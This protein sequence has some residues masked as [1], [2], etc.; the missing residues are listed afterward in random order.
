MPRIF[1]TGTSACITLTA[2]VQRPDL[3]V[4]ITGSGSV[5]AATGPAIA[6][7]APHAWTI[8]NRGT[9]VSDDTMSAAIALDAGGMVVNA[10][11][12]AITGGTGIRIDGVAGTVVNWGRID[13]MQDSGIV[14]SAGGS[15]A[16]RGT[17]TGLAYGVRLVAGG[18]L[19]N[20]GTV[21]A[22]TPGYYH[23]YALGG[24]A[25]QIEG[26][27]VQNHGLISGGV[28]LAASGG[29]I[30]NTGTIRGYQSGLALSGSATASNL[31]VILGGYETVQVGNGTRL[32]NFGMLDGSL[33]RMTIRGQL[34]NAAA[35]IVHG[36]VAAYGGT[37]TVVN[38]GSID[39]DVFLNEGATLINR[40]TMAYVSGVGFPRLPGS[41]VI[42]EG[43][44]A[45]D[46]FVP[47]RF[48]GSGILR[49]SGLVSGKMQGVFLQDGGTV[50]NTGLIQN[51]ANSS[52]FDD[53]AILFQ[54]SGV[55]VNGAGGRIVS[56]RIGVGGPSQEFYTNI[57]T[58]TNLG[59]IAAYSGTEPCAVQVGGGHVVNGSPAMHGALIAGDS[60]GISG[61][62]KAQRSDSSVPL[63]IDNYAIISGGLASVEFGS[64]AG[65][66]LVAH[67]GAAF[68][69][70]LDAF[71]PSDTFALA[72]DT[73]PGLLQNLD[74]HAFETIAVDP[75]ARWALGGIIAVDGATTLRIGADGTL[76]LAGQLVT[77]GDM[78]LQGD[79]TLELGNTSRFAIG[80]APGPQITRTLRVDAARTLTANGHIDGNILGPGLIE[81]DGTLAVDGNVDR[82]GTI[83]LDDFARLSISG[84]IDVGSIVFAADGRVDLGTPTTVHARFGAFN[85]GDLI[86]L[87]GIGLASLVSYAS[88]TLTLRGGGETINLHLPGSL[89]TPGFT[90]ADDGAG[91]TLLGHI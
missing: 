29:S 60:T 43:T 74:L 39:G 2:A 13:G 10:P 26:G 58:I 72:A 30:T 65:N 62:F 9:I 11:D 63:T 48:G 57:V 1:V 32:T 27:T 18:T 31:G 86:D 33:G 21:S 22:G 23:D 84:T 49:N 7:T 46:T 81:V 50:V 76:R 24:V 53:S 20:L 78:H 16:N 91:G 66:R 40:S 52:Y 38:L 19:T 70:A 87:Q 55:L 41:T 25:V 14:L 4:I 88:E 45:S 73:V 44:L 69:G 59:T 28:G 15:V 61:G 83:L 42:N 6:G 47:V 54:R 36:Y 35:G 67:A 71:G 89:G 51:S 37:A 64:A 8:R 82:S 12:A 68:A 75:Q 90:V 85:H 56:P 79:G 80:P 5:H 77:T 17:V 34:V 3:P